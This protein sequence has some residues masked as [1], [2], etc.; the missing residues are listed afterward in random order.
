MVDFIYLVF[1]NGCEYQYCQQYLEDHS[2]HLLGIDN[3][4]WMFS[5]LES[6]TNFETVKMLAIA[7]TIMEFGYRFIE[8]WYGLRDVCQELYK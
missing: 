2:A 7:Y 3:F 8:K 5:L 4:S 6:S 1:W